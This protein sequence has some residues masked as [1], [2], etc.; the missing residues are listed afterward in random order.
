MT[1]LRATTIERSQNKQ[2]GIRTL[3]NCFALAANE[4]KPR[5]VN[6]CV[7]DDR[8]FGQLQRVAVTLRFESARTKIETTDARILDITVIEIIAGNQSVFLIDLVIDTR[9]D[10]KPFL[11]RNRCV[12]EGNRVESHRIE[13]DRINDRAIVD[14]ITAYV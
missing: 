10:S 5:L 12:G 14:I 2:G 7:V 6:R 4:L 1:C 8:R 11:R 3:W 9:I 13:H